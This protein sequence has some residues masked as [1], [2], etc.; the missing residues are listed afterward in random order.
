MLRGG[1]VL[2]GGCRPPPGAGPGDLWVADGAA[3]AL[4]RLDLDLLP[5]E[6]VELDSAAL[7][8]AFP[9]GI[10]AAG[11]SG[12]CASGLD[13]LLRLSRDEPSRVEVA[14]VDVRALCAL[15]DGSALVLDGD[16]PV[17]LL[18]IP[19]RGPC[20]EL[21]CL[22]AGRRLSWGAGRWLLGGPQGE[23]VLGRPEGTVLAWR[24]LEG[25]LEALE[26]AP[27][28]GWWVLVGGRAPGLTRLDPQL[29]VCWRVPVPGGASCLA[30][31]EPGSVW[32]AGEGSLSLLG[33]GGRVELERRGPDLAGGVRALGACRGRLWVALP[34][35]V[36]A[37]ERVG[38]RLG[39]DRTQGGFDGLSA[40][41]PAPGAAVRGRTSGP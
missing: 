3:G 5:V 18:R 29:G 22:P 39:L 8:A 36:L 30:R 10:W 25:P 12:P 16:G 38:R 24:R 27:G 41:A 20:R 11:A 7:L 14:L 26:P 1:L 13:R 9:G 32:V 34:G 2:L 33:P 4:Y 40:L 19:A 31:A 15:E 6:R 17:R 28:E 35:A 37:L 23:L 21:L